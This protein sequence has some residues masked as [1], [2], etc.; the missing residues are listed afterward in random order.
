VRG[1]TPIRTCV[2]CGAPDSKPALLRFVAADDGLRLDAAGRAPGRGAYL[3][4]RAACWAEFVRRR[5]PI[6]S[7]RRAAARTERERL[8]A[9]LTTQASAE[10]AR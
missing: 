9:T 4:R 10:V 7:L 1:D 8:V 6:R 5:G 3:H 2:G